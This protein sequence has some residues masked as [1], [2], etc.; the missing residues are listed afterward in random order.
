MLIKGNAQNW[1]SSKK[2]EIIENA[3]TAYM[4][5]RRSTV[6]DDSIQHVESDDAITHTESGE[7]SE[8]VRILDVALPGDSSGD[9]DDEDLD[10]E[11]EDFE[12]EI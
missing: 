11:I 3:L 5:K 1:S 7:P 12:S 8:K 2:T 4:E 6:L 10:S 9:E